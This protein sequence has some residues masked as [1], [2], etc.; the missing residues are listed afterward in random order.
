M[1]D[2]TLFPVLSDMDALMVLVPSPGVRAT[3]PTDVVNEPAEH[4][5]EAPVSTPLPLI[6]TA[7]PLSE[8]VPLT[9]MALG[10]VTT[11]PLLGL[12]MARVG[13]VLSTS[14]TLLGPA[15]GLVLPARSV[16]TPAAT[17]IATVPSPLH[18]ERVTVRDA[19]PVPV[20]FLVLQLAPPV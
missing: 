10:V 18:P 3:A 19:V 5:V 7:R 9:V 17:E 6:V 15:A 1:F 13:A 2:E 20:T 12:V 11:P 8:Q 4:V 14:S 16:S